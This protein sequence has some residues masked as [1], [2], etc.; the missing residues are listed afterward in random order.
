MR[1]RL[2]ERGKTSGRADDNEETIVKRFRTFVEQSKP[3]V[4][5]YTAKGL[6]H[7]ISAERTPDEVFADVK[8]ALDARLRGV[9]A[10]PAATTDEAAAGLP[11]GS[12]IVFVLGG[13]GSGKGTQC[14][15]I[16][17]HYT[18][19]KHFSA[20]STPAACLAADVAQLGACVLLWPLFAQ[21]L[22]AAPPT[23]QL[24]CAECGC[25]C[26]ADCHIPC[27]NAATGERNGACRR[28]AAR[29]GQGRQRGAGG[30]HEGWQAR[31]DGDDNRAAEGRNGGV[32]RLHLPHR[33][34]PARALLSPLYCVSCVGSG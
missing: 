18:E 11:E 14:E 17:A 21:Q 22:A 15:K 8:A 26:V 2:M 32:R 29:R 5:D 19:V 20:G 1:A 6:C 27:A 12:K 9:T 24:R 34:L 33:R 31:A 10:T 13:P 3:V 28:P 16:V 25:K 23:A 30:H 7:E 4:D